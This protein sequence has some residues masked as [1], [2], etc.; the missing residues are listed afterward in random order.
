[1]KD[2]KANI[3]LRFYDFDNSNYYNYVNHY[4]NNIHNFNDIHNH[5]KYD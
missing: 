3:F 1:M 4:R 2:M 5:N